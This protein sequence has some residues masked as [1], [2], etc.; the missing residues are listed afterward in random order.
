MRKISEFK[1]Y[2]DNNNVE[3][4]FEHLTINRASV[5][6]GRRATMAV[7]SSLPLIEMAKTKSIEKRRISLRIAEGLKNKIKNA[8]SNRV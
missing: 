4:M 7:S 5:P 2:T 8:E 3:D 6:R 1:G